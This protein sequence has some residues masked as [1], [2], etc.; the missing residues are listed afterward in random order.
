[1]LMV[2]PIV[3]SSFFFAQI[4]NFSILSSDTSSSSLEVVLDFGPCCSPFKVD[5]G[6][7]S[8]CDFLDD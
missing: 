2:K 7:I 8:G 1:M 4:K 5:P 6:F 3:F